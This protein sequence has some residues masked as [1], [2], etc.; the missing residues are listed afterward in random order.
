VIALLVLCLVGA[1]PALA[2][3]QTGTINGTVKDPNGE[4]L[5][6]V[7]VQLSGE[8]VMGTRTDVTNAEGDFRFPSMLPGD[9]YRVEFILDGFAKVTHE[10]VIVRVGQTT[11]LPITMDLATVADEIVVTGE[12]PMVDTASPSAS[13]SFDPN[14]LENI[15]Q[16]RNWAQTIVQA[17]GVVSEGGTGLLISSRGGAA[18]TNS[19]S[20]DGVNSSNPIY[21][22]YVTTVVYESVEEVQ[23]VS[24]AMPAEVGNLGG[25]YIN[26]VTKSGGNEFRG[27]VAVYYESDSLQSDNVSDD[28]RDQGIESSPALTDHEDYSFN[29][30]GPIARDKLWF[31]VAHWSAKTIREVNGFPF[32]NGVSS[33]TYFGKLTWQPSQSHSIFVMYDQVDSGQPYAQAN[34]FTSPEATW[35]SENE[36]ELWKVHYSP[37]LSDNAFITLDAAN[38]WTISRLL[39]QADATFAYTDLV[40]AMNWGAH[41]HNQTQD[42]TRNSAKA[43]LS[44]FKDDWAGDHVF[45]FGIDYEL[46]EFEWLT[47]DAPGSDVYLHFMLFGQPYF[48]MIVNN[49]NNS[50]YEMEGINFYA[51]DQWSVSDRVTLSLGVRFNDWT[52]RYPPQSYPGRVYGTAVFPEVSITQDTDVVSW[53]SWEPRIAATIAL[54]DQGKSAL[55]AGF[56][57]YHHAPQFAHFMQA[58]PMGFSYT[59]H[60]WS[61]FDFNATPIPRSSSYRR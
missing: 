2:Q 47:F 3:T 8:T 13:T 59:Y 55:R 23:V 26:V 15:P 54:D 46:D 9:S 49:P 24:G 25:A 44:L 17:P 22:T 16:G 37:I 51:Q 18:T 11:T 43:S 41:N 58:N 38:S 57:R 48:A 6:G 53:S 40:T 34:E 29:V 20:Y 36:Q 39:P 12:T 7:A 4:A 35:V 60:W 5:P 14:I 30:G 27:D 28:L 52:G 45:K 56:A 1:E 31:N 19:F 32:D 33:D 10:D 50:K 21:N 42:T 61:G